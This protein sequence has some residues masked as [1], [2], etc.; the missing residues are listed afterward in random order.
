MITPHETQ[1]NAD[2]QALWDATDERKNDG[3]SIEILYT[4]F[5]R[6][7]AQP[8]STIAACIEYGF[9]EWVGK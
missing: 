4:A 9:G 6:M 1:Q 3:L 8:T 7:Q 5:H 2:L